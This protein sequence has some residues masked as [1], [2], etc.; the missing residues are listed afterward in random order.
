VKQYATGRFGARLRPRAIGAA[1]TG[2][3]LAPRAHTSA[4]RRS[5][6][7]APNR[8]KRFAFY[9]GRRCQSSTIKAVAEELHLDWHTV[10]EL[11]KHPLDHAK[12]HYW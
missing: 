1:V 10:K 5:S 7:R 4:W 3:A 12:S 6:C 2:A 9:V 11:E 8:S